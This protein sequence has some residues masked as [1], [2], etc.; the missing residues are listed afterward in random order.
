MKVLHSEIVNDRVLVTVQGRGASDR[1]RD[2][3][4]AALSAIPRSR[5]R[6]NTEH[7][8]GYG[9]VTTFSYELAYVGGF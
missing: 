7:V 9:A 4:E 8:S 3:R 1:M 6:L 5:I 2:L